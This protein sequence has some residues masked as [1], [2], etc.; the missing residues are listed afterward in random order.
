MS[1]SGTVGAVEAIVPGTAVMEFEGVV[2]HVCLKLFVH[3]RM[4]RAVA[5]RGK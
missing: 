1:Q 3:V 5:E 4:Y 2:A